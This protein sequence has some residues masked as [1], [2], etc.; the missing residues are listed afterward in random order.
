VTFCGKY[1][2]LKCILIK[3]LSYLP[4]RTPT[5]QSFLFSHI[6]PEQEYRIIVGERPEVMKLKIKE[7]CG[8]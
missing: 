1:M 8:L 2:I 5:N 3:K 6:L 4:A 7:Y